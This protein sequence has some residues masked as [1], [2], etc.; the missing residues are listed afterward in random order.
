MISLWQI[1]FPL[2]AEAG[3]G[4]GNG[5]GGKALASQPW[6]L[7]L[8]SPDHRKSQVAVTACWYILTSGDE[9]KIP[10]ASWFGEKPFFSLWWQREIQGVM[11]HQLLASPHTLS[12][13]HTH[14]LHTHTYASRCSAIF[15]LQWRCLP[16]TAHRYR[17]I[18]S[19]WEGSAQQVFYVIRGDPWQRN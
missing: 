10:R 17:L 9:D 8:R 16:G 3:T 2:K 14:I 13:M 12:Y 15:F 18:P 5:S 6:R 7:E 19:A 11:R 4:W 1:K